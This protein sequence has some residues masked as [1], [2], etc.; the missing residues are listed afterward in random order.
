MYYA[1]TWSDYGQDVYQ[2][3]KNISEARDYLNRHTGGE[4]Y[5]NKR[6]K[7]PTSKSFRMILIEKCEP[8]GLRLAAPELFVESD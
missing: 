5:I 6:I 8:Q 3:F 2:K 1:R 4:I 7:T